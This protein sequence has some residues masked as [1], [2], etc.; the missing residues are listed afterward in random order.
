MLMHG[1]KDFF[2][3]NKGGLRIENECAGIIKMY[4]LQT[5]KL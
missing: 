3:L 5:Y 4:Q 1:I 2:I